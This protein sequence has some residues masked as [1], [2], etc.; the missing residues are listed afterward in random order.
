MIEIG[1]DQN[2]AHVGNLIMERDDDEPVE[3]F[4]ERARALAREFESDV[5]IWGRLQPVTWVDDIQTIEIEG[6]L[7]PDASGDFAQLGAVRIVRDIVPAFR[8]R[9]GR[10][11]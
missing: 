6:G 2:F 10:G 4:R 11:D 3:D 1:E 5:L 8:A 9:G 7:E